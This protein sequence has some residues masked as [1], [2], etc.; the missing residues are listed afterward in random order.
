MIV[1]LSYVGMVKSCSGSNLRRL[2]RGASAAIWKGDRGAGKLMMVMCEASVA[3][4]N[5][6]SAEE[7]E[8]G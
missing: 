8:V 6:I 3:V 7:G 1:V 2:F 5:G 4:K